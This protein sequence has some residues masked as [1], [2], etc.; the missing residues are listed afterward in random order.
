VVEGASWYSRCLSYPMKV[1]EKRYVVRTILCTMYLSL[2]KEYAVS[3]EKKKKLSVK[4][5]E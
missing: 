3:S 2:L 1:K 5:Y 4:E